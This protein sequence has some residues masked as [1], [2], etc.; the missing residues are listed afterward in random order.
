[1]EALGQKAPL[2]KGP[3]VAS[4]PPRLAHFWWVSDRRWLLGSESEG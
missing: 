4:E 2:P 1:M 3:A